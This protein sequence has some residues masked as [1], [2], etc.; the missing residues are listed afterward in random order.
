MSGPAM[1]QALQTG[2]LDAGEFIGPWTDSALGYYQVAPYYYWPGV[3][4]PS[5]AEEC[6]INAAVFAELPDDLKEVVTQACQGLYN[7]VWTEYMT[8]HA[9]ALQTLVSEHN[10]QVRK[11][12]DDVIAAMG[13]AAAE[14]MQEYLADDDELV[15]R[16]TESFIAYR[17][18]V[19]GYMTY[20]DNGQMNARA[21]VLGY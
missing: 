3:G 1:F 10:V 5:S 19:G 13:V 2:A 4:E 11:L 20:A 14:I 12:P 8:K 17:D 9:Q 21:G 7:P 15:V 18:L 16:I 6:G